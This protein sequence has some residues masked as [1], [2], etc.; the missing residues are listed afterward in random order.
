[1]LV[2][3]VDLSFICEWL[4]INLLLDADYLSPLDEMLLAEYG[5]VI[6]LLLKLDEGETEWVLSFLISPKLE[7]CDWAKPAEI[8]S[9]DV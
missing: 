7:E 2:V 6:R 1:L 9:K 8:F 3:P 5:S 4:D